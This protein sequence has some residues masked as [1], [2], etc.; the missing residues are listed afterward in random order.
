MRPL[1]PSSSPSSQPGSLDGVTVG[2]DTASPGKQH[3]RE[4]RVR[5]V[6][7][8]WG[9]RQTEDTAST[10]CICACVRVKRAEDTAIIQLHQT[11]LWLFLSFFIS[12]VNLQF[13]YGPNFFLNF[14]S[15]CKMEPST[16]C[17]SLTDVSVHRTLWWH[18]FK[19]KKSPPPIPDLST[20]WANLKFWVHLKSQQMHGGV[21]SEKF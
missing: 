18:A 19:K 17:F 3:H 12:T 5:E 2:E 11:T 6:L 15:S 16:H 9:K 7:V 21:V 10:V 20:K 4:V 8:R 1:F 13:V 14:T